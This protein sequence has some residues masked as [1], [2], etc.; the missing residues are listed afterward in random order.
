[1]GKEKKEVYYSFGRFIISFGN[2]LKIKIYY[3]TIRDSSVL[4]CGN[5]EHGER[6]GPCVYESC[7]RRRVAL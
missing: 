2:V 6:A 5:I 1:M 7:S 4:H 3:N